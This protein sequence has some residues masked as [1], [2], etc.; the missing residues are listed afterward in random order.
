MR[1]VFVDTSAWD[2]L[3]DR[4][5]SNHAAA[6]RYRAILRQERMPLYVINFVLDECYTL[7]LHNVGYARTVAFKGTI[8]RMQAGNVLTVVHV[9]EEIERAA[10]DVFARFNQD[11]TWSFTDCTTKVV[12]DSLGIQHIFAFNYHFE[13]MGF[14]RFPTNNR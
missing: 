6:V 7:L 9:S 12:M 5:D 2:A 11:K 14:L 1:A 4:S 13:Q 3:E 8:D 10:W